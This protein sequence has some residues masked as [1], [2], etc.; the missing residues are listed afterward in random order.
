MKNK[1][2]ARSL[3]TLALAVRDDSVPRLPA[4]ARPRQLR[5][6]R[7]PAGIREPAKTYKVAIIKQLDHA[8]LDE[9]A[10]AIAAELDKIAAGATA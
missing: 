6:Q 5:G 1:H 10:N 8:S 9:I 4:A 7:C 2:D 3:L